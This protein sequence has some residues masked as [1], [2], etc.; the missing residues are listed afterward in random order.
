MCPIRSDRRGAYEY[1]LNLF[2]GFP[3]LLAF[4]EVSL[5]PIKAGE[6]FASIKDGGFLCVRLSTYYCWLLAAL[7][8]A[9]KVRCSARLPI[10]S[11]RGIDALYTS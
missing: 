3:M 4:L 7:R 8:A 5:I 2:D 1:A 9:I 11:V 6:D 10:I